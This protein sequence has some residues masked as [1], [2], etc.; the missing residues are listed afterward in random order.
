MTAQIIKRN[1]KP[2]YAVL[3]YDE[4]QD[5]VARLEDLEDIA[6]AD[7]VMAALKRGEEELIP[8]ELGD[9]LMQGE[10][11]I[12]VWRQYRGVTQA[13]LANAAGITAAYV[14]QL[15][16]GK[17]QPSVEVLRAMARKLSVD[18]DDLLSAAA[19]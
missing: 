7:E 15:E 11:P 16:A 19:D 18:I 12:R 13:A 14:S 4:Y 10:S 1:G 8:A 17:R 5:M 2:E 3:P 9:A 6:A